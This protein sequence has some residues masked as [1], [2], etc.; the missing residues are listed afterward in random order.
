MRACLAVVLLAACGSDTTTTAYFKISDRTEFYELPFPN[1]YWRKDDGHV[2]LSQFPT[3]SLIAMNVKTI[4][5]RDCDGFGKNA[6]MFARFSAPLDE[7]TLPDP[8]ASVT[9]AASV[10]V[11]NVDPASPER[12][13][14][15]PVIVK[16]HLEKTQTQGDNRLAVRPYPGFPLDDAT[17][18]ALV[19]TNRVHGADGGSISRDGDFSALVGDGGDAKAKAVFAFASPPFSTSAEKSLS[20]AIASPSAP[21]TRLVITSAYVVPS[22]SGKPG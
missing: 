3:N 7:T 9:D 5:E 4:A 21:W 6:A 1:D 14:K 17:T 13:Q 11:V 8:A 10:Y 2:D 15:T 22:S 19:I 16:F 18:Y 12:G 20:R